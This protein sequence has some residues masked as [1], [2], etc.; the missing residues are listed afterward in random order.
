MQPTR[1]CA[2]T[3]E[4][5]LRAPPSSEGV[6]RAQRSLPAP[7]SGGAP[8]LTPTKAGAAFSHR[9]EQPGLWPKERTPCSALALGRDADANL[10]R[11]RTKSAAGVCFALHFYGW[12]SPVWLKMT[13]SIAK[14]IKHAPD[15][16][17]CTEPQQLLKSKWMTGRRAIG[18]GCEILLQP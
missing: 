11:S 4:G 15:G 8:A 12:N 7:G 16:P 14:L 10:C 2:G 1:A 18:K 17:F 13:F 6:S 5:E 9:P 3:Y